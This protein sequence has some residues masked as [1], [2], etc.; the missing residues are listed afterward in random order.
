EPR[1]RP[2]RAVRAVGR[3]RGDLVLS[4]ALELGRPDLLELRRALVQDATRDHQ[5]LDLLRALE[6]VEDL[7]VARPLLEQL[8]LAVAKAAAQLHAAQRDRVADA[9][10]FRLA[11]AGLERVRLAVVG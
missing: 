11:H 10:G 3:G 4:R 6:D 9:P 5:Q 8:G 7:R 2:P 1:H